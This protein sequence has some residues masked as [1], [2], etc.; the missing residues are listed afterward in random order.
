MLM[1]L[2]ALFIANH[3]QS[4]VSMNRD[5]CIWICQSWFGFKALIT[6]LAFPPEICYLALLWFKGMVWGQASHW[7]GS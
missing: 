2:N 4:I 7:E 3:L 5:F 1:N 6:Y